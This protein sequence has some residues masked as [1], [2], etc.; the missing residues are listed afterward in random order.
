MCAIL[1]LKSL[2]ISFSFIK[3]ITR[4]IFVCIWRGQKS[5]I[6]LQRVL[7]QGSW[8]KLECNLGNKNKSLWVLGNGP[9]LAAQLQEYLDAFLQ[10]DIMC[11]NHFASTEYFE[12]LKPR[13]Y[14]M[15][16][17]D[18]FGE[19]YNC[20]LQEKKRV[21]ETFENIHK[22]LTWDMFLIIPV[23]AKKYKEFIKYVTSN[24]KIHVR[25]VSTVKFYGYNWLKK[26]LLDKQLCS[27]G[28]TNVLTNSLY[29]AIHMGYKD[30][31][32]FGVEHG[33]HKQLIVTDNNEV[34][35]QNPHFYE[36]DASY[37]KLDGC[38]ISD[39]FTSMAEAFKSYMELNEYCITK[40]GK[41]RNATPGSF[42]DAF[43]RVK[44]F[45]S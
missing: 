36:K 39:I 9:S 15:V 33:W 22:K 14:V 27:F 13:Y 6:W 7:M 38:N 5:V 21:K 45:F 44:N 34:A 19:R 12:K 35:M 16:D 11:M 2:G 43:E 41:I 42:I 4:K 37:D 30:I 8:E 25:Y 28:A 40:G 29:S 32:V 18:F 26:L 24:N 1:F 17:P 31:L 3:K 10:H 23:R 20:P